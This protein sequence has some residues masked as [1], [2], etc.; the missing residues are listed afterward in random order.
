MKKIIIP[1][2]SA[3]FLLVLVTPYSFAADS[4]YSVDRYKKSSDSSRYKVKQVDEAN[5]VSRAER[6]RQVIRER[7]K[8]SR[9]K[10]YTLDEYF[11]SDERKKDAK[12]ASRHIDNY[13]N[14]I[15]DVYADKKKESKRPQQYKRQ[16]KSNEKHKPPS[17]IE[18]YSVYGED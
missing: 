13:I 5:K 3:L 12:S 10:N 9:T 17:S 2:M 11:E 16:K 7:E 4:R 14:L 15:D 8:E 18:R 1:C 6:I